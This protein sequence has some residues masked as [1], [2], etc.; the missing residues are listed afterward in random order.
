MTSELV[1]PSNLTYLSDAGTRWSYHNIFQKLM[2]VV[3][4]AGNQTFE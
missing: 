2:D 3:A 1:I 4:S